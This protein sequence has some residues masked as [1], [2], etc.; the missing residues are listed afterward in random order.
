VSATS[1]PWLTAALISTT[2]ILVL[3]S[4]PATA[5]RVP[6]FSGADKIAHAVMYGAAAYSWRA[7]FNTPVRTAT[8]WVLAGLAVFGAV[9]E[10]HQ[11]WVPGRMP[12]LRDWL[13]DV[14]GIVLALGAWYFFSRR[15]GVA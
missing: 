2:A 15:V 3:N 11:R 9:D 6:S 7:T 5:A 12:D 1:K 4:L 8:W 10:V 13:A 14:A